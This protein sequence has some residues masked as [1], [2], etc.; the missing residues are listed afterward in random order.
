MEKK[1]AKV[2]IIGAGVSG[3]AAANVWKKCG[4]EVTLFEAS[5]QVGGQWNQT[6]PGVSLQNTAPQYQFSEFP[7]PFK[8]DRHPSGEDVLKYLNQAVEEFALTI[9]FNHRLKAMTADP[10]G[11]QLTFENGNSHHFGYVVIATGQYPGGD[12]KRLPR[13]NN[14]DLYQGDIITNIDSKEVFK[15]KNVA[16][17]G[18][19][20]T[21]LDFATWSS[22]T[23]NTTK[24]IFRT[25]RWTIPDYLLGID[26][27]KPFFARI[28]SGMMPSWGASTWMQKLLHNR[29]PFIVNGFWRLI[30]NLFL[31]QHRQD[32]KLGSIE[33][34]VLDVV[35]PPK[36]Q[37]MADFRSASALA[38]KR[39]YEYIAHQG[40]SPYRGEVSAFYEDGIILSDGQKI[41]AD[42]VCLCCGNEAPNYDYLPKKYA[43][44]LQINGGPSLYRHQIEPRIPNLGFAG[45]NHG[46]MHI[47]LAE[48]GALW[49]IA[50]YEQTF[51]LPS[52]ED[53]LASAARVM[54]WKK[55]HSSYESTINMA[56]NTRYQQHLDILMQ[57]MGISQWRKMPNVFAEVFSRYDPTDYKG[58]IKEYLTKSQQTSFG[59]I[60]P[61]VAVDA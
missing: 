42:M 60:K 58:V 13:F 38:P 37:F 19:G 17:I 18:F 27:T 3:I 57:D 50:A 2:A 48:M 53:M 43:Q 10:Q 23:A 16:V 28:G 47:A 9:Q 45:Y 39:Y 12:Q 56:V 46:F 22:E 34:K 24:H 6:Y 31:Y 36:S 20:K 54:Q 55:D 49:Q 5:E 44:F 8:T 15:D 35:I 51:Q 26:Y 4:Y 11:W 21:A 41:P 33:K 52:E 61:T 14:M 32:A 30:C 7:W 29:L 1:K 25:P 40:I 59:A